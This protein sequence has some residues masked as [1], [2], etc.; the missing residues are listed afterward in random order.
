MNIVNKLLDMYT[1]IKD[2]NIKHISNITDTNVCL[3]ISSLMFSLLL[4]FIIDLYNFIQLT[5]M[6]IMTGIKIIF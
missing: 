5:D 2:D 6:Q 4:S 3:I 1:S